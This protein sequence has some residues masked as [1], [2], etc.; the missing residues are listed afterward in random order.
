MFLLELP[1]VILS[2]RAKANLFNISVFRS[3]KTEAVGIFHETSARNPQ[4]VAP[5]VAGMLSRFSVV[6][7]KNVNACITFSDFSVCKVYC[8]SVFRNRDPCFAFPDNVATRVIQRLADSFFMK[9]KNKR[10]FG[11]VMRKFFLTERVPSGMT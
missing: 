9:P 1:R 7:A 3:N 11:V 6:L 4:C 5:T 10:I 2:L 8:K